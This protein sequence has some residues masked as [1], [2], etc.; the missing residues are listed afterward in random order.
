MAG[1]C[2]HGYCPQEGEGVEINPREVPTSDFTV[3]WDGFNWD[4]MDDDVIILRSE[5][6][7][8]RSERYQGTDS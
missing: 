6:V 3:R 8:F 2:D 7:I 4:T 5:P 1:I